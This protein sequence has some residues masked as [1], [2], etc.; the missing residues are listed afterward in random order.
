MVNEGDADLRIRW[1][2]FGSRTVSRLPILQLTLPALTQEMDESDMKVHLPKTTFVAIAVS[3]LV[4]SACGSESSESASAVATSSAT[5]SA[6]EAE[7][8]GDYQIGDTAPGG[9]IVFFDAGSVQPWGRYL[10]AGP[11]LDSAEW[12]GEGVRGLDGRPLVR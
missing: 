5:E 10:E 2:W 12:C 11:Q 6:E 1:R 7:I 9:G 8:P 3:A 4:L